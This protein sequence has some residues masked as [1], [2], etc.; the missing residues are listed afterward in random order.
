MS[1]RAVCRQMGN[2]FSKRP[3]MKIWLG[4]F[5]TMLILPLGVAGCAMDVGSVD[6]HQTALR[7]LDSIE[8][9]FLVLLNQSCISSFTARRPAASTSGL[10]G[11]LY[12]RPGTISFFLQLIA[13]LAPQLRSP[14]GIFA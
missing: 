10:H 3:G 5:A 6:S 2:G 13:H 7:D 8:N 9:D 4:T 12:M 11:H 14:H 1:G